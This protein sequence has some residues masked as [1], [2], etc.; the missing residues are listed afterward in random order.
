MQAVLGHCNPSGCRLS[1]SPPLVQQTGLSPGSFSASTGTQPVVLHRCITNRME[2]QLARS[3]PLGTVASPG[4]R[5]AH[6]LARARGHPISCSSVGTSVAQSDC[7]RV[8]RQQYRS[9]L[10]PQ[11]GRDPFHISVQQN[12]GT[13]SSSGPVRNTSHSNSPTRS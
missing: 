13:L 8:V 11:T 6:Q 10:H 2:S 1:L 9:G 12:S 3:S 7:S 4:L 5:S